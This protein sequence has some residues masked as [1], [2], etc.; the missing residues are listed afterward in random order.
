LTTAS[1]VLLLVAGLVVAIAGWTRATRAE[2]RSQQ[3]LETLAQIFEVPL[4]M[5]DVLER[6]IVP[7]EKNSEM[8]ERIEAALP[9]LRDLPEGN[10]FS[11]LA[12]VFH[13]QMGDACMKR[14][15]LAKAE[16]HFFRCVELWRSLGSGSPDAIEPPLRLAT[17]TA[18]VGD[19]CRE[20]G[21]RVEAEA[22]YR[23][24]L[25]IDEELAARYTENDDVLD[26]LAWSYQRLAALISQSRQTAEACELYAK[27]LH[28]MR[29]AFARKPGDEDR[30]FGVGNMHFDLAYAMYRLAGPV[31]EVGPLYEKAMELA[32]RL[33]REHPDNPDYADL[34]P[35]CF[36]MAAQLWQDRGDPDRAQ[37]AFYAGVQRARLC[38]DSGVHLLSMRSCVLSALQE[39][40]ALELH[41]GDV[42]QVEDALVEARSCLKDLATAGWEH[43]GAHEVV[44]LRLEGDLAMARGEPASAE[45]IWREVLDVASGDKDAR[46]VVLARLDRHGMSTTVER[47]ELEQRMRDLEQGRS[48]HEGWLLLDLQEALGDTE[49]MEATR[50]RL[51][52][53]AEPVVQRVRRILAGSK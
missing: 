6:S 47:G 12:A 46:G 44:I 17:A 8:L 13:E 41:R 1:V 11:R 48:P 10:R 19:A 16:D 7:T 43:T 33:A 51:E 27:A 34:Y 31:D 38:I 23:T 24:A 15:D 37:A 21:L 52:E 30:V 42:A 4:A 3:Q 14:G 32:E 20:R 26:D 2:A 36:G 45:R 28:S 39:L 9:V 25:R 5:A 18:K 35:T 49:G 53:A 50:R 22:H 40:A 29:Q